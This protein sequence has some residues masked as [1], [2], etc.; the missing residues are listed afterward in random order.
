MN[1]NSGCN[2]YHH[3]NEKFT[4]VFNSISALVGERISPFEDM[5]VEISQSENSKIKLQ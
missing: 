4:K 5:S 1:R 3:Q 2:K